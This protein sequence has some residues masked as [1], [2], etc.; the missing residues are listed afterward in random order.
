M[1]LNVDGLPDLSKDPFPDKI[2][3]MCEHIFQHHIVVLTETR[4]NDIFRLLQFIDMTHS[5][6]AHSHVEISGRRGQ[7]VVVLAVRHLAENASVLDISQNMC[8][9]QFK[10]DF[11]GFPE[12]LILG[13]GCVARDQLCHALWGLQCTYWTAG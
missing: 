9:M 2:T 13:A 3:W 12:D 11:F 7:G 8:W 5:V 4:T 10:K 6:V 1:C